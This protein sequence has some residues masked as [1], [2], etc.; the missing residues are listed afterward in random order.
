MD[1]R[2][3]YLLINDVRPDHIKWLSAFQEDLQVDTEKKVMYYDYDYDYDGESVFE[4]RRQ[5]DSERD[6]RGGQQ[7]A[8]RQIRG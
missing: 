7:D 4:Y 6:G 5:R 1:F 3:D 2:I 8:D